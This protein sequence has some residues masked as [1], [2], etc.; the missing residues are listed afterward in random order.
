MTET[1]KNMQMIIDLIPIGH[2][3]AI[4]RERLCN[5]SGLSD[6][7]VRRAIGELNEAGNVILNRGEGYFRYDAETDRYYLEHYLAVEKGR[8]RTLNRKLRKMR[9]AAGL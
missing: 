7:E 5:R 6:R 9:K 4:S 1:L 3:N 2:E 8:I